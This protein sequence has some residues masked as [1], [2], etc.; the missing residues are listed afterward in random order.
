VTRTSVALPELFDADWMLGFLRARRA[1][2][3]ESIGDTA[4]TRA[5]RLDGRA[6]VVRLEIDARR[7]AV[8]IESATRVPPRHLR[9]LATRL[10]DLDADLDGFHEALGRD[11]L[12]SRLVRRRPALRVPQFIDP[13]ECLVRA[14]LGQQV[15]VRGAATM[16]DRV[17]RAV[18]E[19]LGDFFAFPSPE[20]MA[21]AG[22]IRL[23]QL[24]LTR[25]KA[26]ALHGI[27]TSIARGELDL[28]ALRGAGAEEAQAALDALPGVGPWTASYIRMRGFGDRDAFPAADLGIVKAMRAATR[29]GS[30]N[31][32]EIERRAERWRPWRAYVAV[33]LWN[34]LNL[35][36]NGPAKAGP[37]R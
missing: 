27:A 6:I 12:V 37:Y 10:L 8:H 29:N 21:Q 36:G 19:P 31:V 23:R 7:R 9:A 34:S 15:S 13:F 4:V 32:A 2:A 33:H 18:G 22:A 14:I 20:A 35:L 5:V 11:R 1:P 3:L 25:A 17:T 16:V 26:S 24:G 28:A 30:L